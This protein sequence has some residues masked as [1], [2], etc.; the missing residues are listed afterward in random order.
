MARWIGLGLKECYDRSDWGCFVLG[1][2]GT[3]LG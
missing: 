1:N 3:A 2:H